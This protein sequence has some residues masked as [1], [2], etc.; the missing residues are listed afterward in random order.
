MR[1]KLRLT[2]RTEL[3]NVPV[4]QRCAVLLHCA[5]QMCPDCNREYTNRTWQ[6]V[7][8]LRQKRSHEAADASKSGL[9]AL[10]MALAKNKDV[11]KHVLRIDTAKHGFDF[12]FL[13]I[14]HAQAFA[15]YLQ[16]VAPMRVKT[17]KKLVSTDVKSNTANLKHTIACDVVP[18]CKDD[19]VLIHRHAPKCKLAGRLVL[20][21][22]KPT[23]GVLHLMDAS[24]KRTCMEDSVME[25][26]AESYYKHEKYY[27][28]VLSSHRLQRFVALDAELCGTKTASSSS[29]SSSNNNKYK[30]PSSGVDKY[31]LADLELVRESDFGVNDETI[32][33]VT[34]LGN[35]VSAGDVVMGYDLVTTNVDELD[36][37][38]NNNFVVPDVVV[39]KKVSGDADKA[40][41]EQEQSEDDDAAAKR[42]SKKKERRRHKK[43]GKKMRE[44]E[45]S[46][47]RMGFLQDDEYDP[48]AL[49]A[50]L[51]N[52][53]ELA[54]EVSALG[55]DLEALG[56]S[57]PT[58][59]AETADDDEEEE[60][61]QNEDWN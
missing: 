28:V 56:A 32:Q 14:P 23:Q 20:V 31:A 29:S 60:V 19:L 21:V 11:R 57:T 1:F 35:L 46:A 33:T 16:R 17:T 52:D 5:F 59:V 9:A 8:Q 44:L 53:P 10:E 34:H 12:Y 7:V 40:S 38:L 45:E 41:R 61:E 36:H 15:S 27:R 37:S 25:L 55:R 58:E 22:S 18:L 4:Q 6:A 51:A 47:Q 30:G 43:E 24:P 49:E 2:V 13:E 42:V 50:E 48:A 26:S 39:V 3:Q 54:A